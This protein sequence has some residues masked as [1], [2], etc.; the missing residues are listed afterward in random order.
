MNY[1]GMSKNKPLEIEV[2]IEQCRNR[3]ITSPEFHRGKGGIYLRH[4]KYCRD[5]LPRIEALARIRELEAVLGREHLIEKQDDIN[6]RINDLI[7]LRN[8][9][10]EC[11]ESVEREA[12]KAEVKDTA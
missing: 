11:R 7:E 9:N 3:W 5:C 1:K 10:Q 2:Q 4:D 6:R 8:A 12:H